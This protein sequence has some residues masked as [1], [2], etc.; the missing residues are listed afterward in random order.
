MSLAAYDRSAL[1]LVSVCTS[2]FGSKLVGLS[3]P[4]EAL[5]VSKMKVWMWFWPVLT[6]TSQLSPG[7][8]VPRTPATTEASRRFPP[9]CGVKPPGKPS[10]APTKGSW[11]VKQFGSSRT[12]PKATGSGVPLTMFTAVNGVHAAAVVRVAEVEPAG[13]LL[14]GVVRVAVELGSLPAGAEVDEHLQVVIDQRR[15]PRP[16]RVAH[17]AVAAVNHRQR[18]AVLHRAVGRLGAAVFQAEVQEPFRPQRQTGV[19]GERL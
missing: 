10:G 4:S 3:G 12:A 19:A 18:A 9:N 17:V 6:L 1:R 13:H 8:V 11:K 15:A 2:R 14:A 16:R 7:I 5:T